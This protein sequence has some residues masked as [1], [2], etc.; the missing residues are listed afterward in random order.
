MGRKLAFCYNVPFCR[1][2]FFEHVI[3]F[4]NK[5]YLPPQIIFIQN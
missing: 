2:E 1:T 4:F 3:E 5:K